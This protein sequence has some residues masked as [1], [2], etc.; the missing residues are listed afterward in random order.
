MKVSFDPGR[1]YAE[2][3][4]EYIEKILNRTNIL[5][6]NEDELKILTN[7]DYNT[8]KESDYGFNGI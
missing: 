7:H 6:V 4:L 2:K 5:L 3:G 1:I 8:F